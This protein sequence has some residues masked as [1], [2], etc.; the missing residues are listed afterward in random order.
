MPL[1]NIQLVF[2]G[3]IQPSNL[4]ILNF[5]TVNSIWLLTFAINSNRI[6]LYSNYSVIRLYSH[7][8]VWLFVSHLCVFGCARF[9]NWSFCFSSFP[10]RRFIFFAPCLHL[11]IQ[12]KRVSNV[13]II[14]C[15][16]Y[17]FTRS[18]NSQEEYNAFWHVLRIIGFCLSFANSCANPIA[19]YFVSAAF[20][21]HFNR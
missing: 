20:R 1:F 17:A 21:K 6:H 15:T 4:Y 9:Y 16:R 2:F 18:D 19:L 7:F 13:C 10:L 3:C 12:L 11:S 14:Y 5:Q 8:F